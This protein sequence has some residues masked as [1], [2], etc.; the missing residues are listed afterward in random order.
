M[1]GKFS[2][3]SGGFSYQVSDE[4]LEAFAR[5]SLYERLIWVDEMRLFTLMARTPETTERQERLRRGE[6]IVPE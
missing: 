4:Q 5:L 3:P 2:K 1:Q 6:S